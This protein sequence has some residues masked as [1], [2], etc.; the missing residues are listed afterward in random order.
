[1]LMPIELRTNQTPRKT[2]CSCVVGQVS[3]AQKFRMLITAGNNRPFNLWCHLKPIFFQIFWVFFLWIPLWN[4]PLFWAPLQSA[5]WRDAQRALRNYRLF[6]KAD[7]SSEEKSLF[8]TLLMM[9]QSLIPPLP[10]FFAISATSIFPFRFSS[11]DK[12]S[13][14]RGFEPQLVWVLRFLR[15]PH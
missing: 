3:E 1:M 2:S 13:W 6:F 12:G 9:L 14:N 11:F 5:R 8:T 4:F 10:P 7:W 15:P